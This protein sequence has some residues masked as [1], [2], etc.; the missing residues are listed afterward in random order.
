MALLIEEE[1]ELAAMVRA[2]GLYLPDG[3]LRRD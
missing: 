2:S 1:P 3:I